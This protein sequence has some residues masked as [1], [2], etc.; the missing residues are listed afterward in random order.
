MA[1]EGDILSLDNRREDHQATDDKHF[2][3]IRENNDVD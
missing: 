2:R 1:D 3:D